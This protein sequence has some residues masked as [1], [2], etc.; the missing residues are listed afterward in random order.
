MSISPI[1]LDP[2][3]DRALVALVARLV[4]HQSHPGVRRQEEASGVPDPE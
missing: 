2:G 3:E 4:R 1:T